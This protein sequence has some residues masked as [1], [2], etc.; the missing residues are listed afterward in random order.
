MPFFTGTYEAGYDFMRPKAYDESHQTPVA[1]DV[2][3][4][5][6][7]VIGGVY[8]FHSYSHCIFKTPTITSKKCSEITACNDNPILYALS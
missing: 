7:A 5:L 2:D 1:L 6:G 3:N 8:R 4:C